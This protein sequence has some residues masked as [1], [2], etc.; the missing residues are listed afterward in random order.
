MQE[1]QLL[2]AMAVLGMVAAG[3]WAA[4][5]WLSRQAARRARHDC[6]S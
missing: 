1:E 6:R 5:W 4:G 2:I 3:I